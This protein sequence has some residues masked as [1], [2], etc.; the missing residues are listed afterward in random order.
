MKMAKRVVFRKQ[1]IMAAI[2]CRICPLENLRA[3]L[4]LKKVG[5]DSSREFCCGQ[6][7][8]RPSQSAHFITVG[9]CRSQPC[10]GQ[11]Q[12]V[13]RAGNEHAVAWGTI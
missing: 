9:G 1:S 8:T 7:I 11:S 10:L 6:Y 12:R 5:F 4:L 2:I 13:G 3:N